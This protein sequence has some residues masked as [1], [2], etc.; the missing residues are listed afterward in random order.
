SNELKTAVLG[1]DPQVLENEGAVSEP[2]VA[3]MA[4]GARKRANVEIGLATS[5]IAGP[6][7]GSD[8]KPVGTVCIGLSRAGSV[9]TWRYQLPQWG[10]RRI[11]ILTAW[12]AL[13]H[14]QGRDPS[15]AN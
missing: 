4:E 11:K 2:V 15:E 1:V 13:A 9:Q 8:E 14:L 10:R 7:G 6:S 5:G 12:L 3:A